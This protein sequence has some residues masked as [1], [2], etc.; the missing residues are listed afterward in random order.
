MSG[1]QQAG[2]VSWGLVLL[3]DIIMLA[4]WGSSV[5]PVETT[6]AESL[7]RCRGSPLGP[8]SPGSLPFPLLI[9]L[10]HFHLPL[11]TVLPN[12]VAQC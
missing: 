7:L 10:S 3:G 5:V 4:T 1:A 12:M 6:S 11:P 9:F 8:S 2:L